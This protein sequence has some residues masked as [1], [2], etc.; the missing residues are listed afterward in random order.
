MWGR[1][2]V[3]QHI[4]VYSILSDAVLEIGDSVLIRSSTKALAVQRQQELYFGKEADYKPRVWFEQIPIPPLPIPP[5]YI[6]KYHENPNIYVGRISI[7]GIS[8]ASVVQIGNT[9][10]VHKE[11]RVDHIRQLTGQAMRPKTK[12]EVR[13]D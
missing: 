11:S 8:T 12:V 9:E 10:H 5:P 4:L 1:N 6:R 13:R 3:V 7:K 2:S